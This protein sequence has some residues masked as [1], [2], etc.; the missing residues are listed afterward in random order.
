M[1]HIRK[2]FQNPDDNPEGYRF[3]EGKDENELRT[4]LVDQPVAYNLWKDA[5]LEE[6]MYVTFKNYIYNI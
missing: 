2:I 5:D 4:Y 3:I 1:E 6:L